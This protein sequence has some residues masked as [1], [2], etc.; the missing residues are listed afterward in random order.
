MP[1][2]NFSELEEAAPAKINNPTNM[3]WFNHYGGYIIET[4]WNSDKQKY[5]TIYHPYDLPNTKLMPNE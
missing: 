1:Q 5:E 2:L 3:S 4:K